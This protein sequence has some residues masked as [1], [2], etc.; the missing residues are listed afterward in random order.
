MISRCQRYILT[1]YGRTYCAMYD[2]SICRLSL[3][4]SKQLVE[5]I[6]PLVSP[7]NPIK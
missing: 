3:D 2:S 7:I 1:G 4:L 6:V 5:A